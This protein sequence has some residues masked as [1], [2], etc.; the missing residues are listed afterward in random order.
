M[1]RRDAVVFQVF[2]TLRAKVGQV[3]Q[4][5]AVLRQERDA[6]RE[7]MAAAQQQFNEDRRTLGSRVEQLAQERASLLR[8]SDAARECLASLQGEHSELLGQVEQQAA[9]LR[10]ERDVAHEQLSAAQQ[11]WEAERRA[12]G[13]QAE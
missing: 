11:Q 7:N 13:N 10:Q 2:G 3:E 1:H 8:E 5:A 9:V 12:L 6:A 4:Q